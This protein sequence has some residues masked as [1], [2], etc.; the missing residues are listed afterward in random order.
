M[1]HFLPLFFLLLC[2]NGNAQGNQQWGSYFSYTNVVDL[3]QSGSRLFAASQ[4]A[5]FSQNNISGELK[6]ITS[7]DGLKTETISAI[8]YSATYNKTLV[9]SSNGLLVIINANNSI[10]SKNAIVQETTVVAT[11]KKINHIYEYNGIAYLST[12]F[13]IVEF[14][15]ATLEFGDT[16]Y[17][18]PNGAEVAVRQAT[19][20][21][22]YIYAATY[23]GFGIR[24][25]LL[26]NPNLNDFNQWQPQFGG[27][28]W[29][30]ILTYGTGLFAI[31]ND[32][33][34]HR[35]Q[36]DNLV[37]F[38]R[39]P[40]AATD[41]RESSGF[42]IATCA[43]KTI[44]Y[45]SQFLQQLQIN[46]IPGE[47]EDITYTCA[48][49]VGQTFYI[50]TAERGVFSVPMNFS[51]P[52][53][54]IT[55]DGPLR[56]N[57]FSIKKSRNF[58]WAVFGGYNTFYTPDNKRYGVSKLT[59]EGWKNIPYDDLAVFGPFE[60]ISDISINPNNEKEVYLNSGHSGLLK[61]I[62]N[63]P[64]TLY[65]NVTPNNTKLQTVQDYTGTI[66]Y[67]SVRINGGTFDRNNNLWM[68]NAHV[69]KP[70][71]VLSPGGGW[72][73]Y[74]LVDV[75][76]N[77]KTTSYGKML[78]DRNGTK[79]LPTVAEGL[80]GFNEALNNKFIVV[81]AESGL[82]STYVKCVE[83]DN[84]NRLWI[85]TTSGLRTLYADRF[86]TE[87]TLEATNIVFLED[88]VPVEL[89]NEQSIIDIKTDG[90]NNKWIGTAGA[91]AFLV[92]PDGQSTLFHFT[93]DNSP[94][95]S[96]NIND[97]EIDNSTGEV[98]FAT[99]KGLVSYKGTSTEAEDDL[100]NV[101]VY[102]NPVRP[103]F[104]GD[105][106]ISGL[107]NRATVKI[108][109]IE[110]NLVYE[111]TS[112]GGTILWDTRA[113]GKYKVASGVYMIFISSEDASLTKVKKVMVVR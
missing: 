58:L 49:I 108:T 67:T 96:N 53:V 79:W 109:D 85:G 7:V 9:G 50:G 75:L 62:D 66:P 89:M 23:E 65:N 11:K 37:T 77:L 91:G 64:T 35:V 47:L 43:T 95:P 32:G 94:L 41:L 27:T 57:V 15:L 73:E 106:K 103:G 107:V 45:N 3:A 26:A 21:N 59:N 39:L 42:M 18:G 4:N 88:G 69:E 24:R 34:I 30:G 2:L 97:I 70:L 60:S 17:L 100:S 14:N 40:S 101:Y 8:Y 38:G 28:Y 87:N 36:G 51:A 1:K 12:D 92:S 105:V 19:I 111:T 55:P 104:E 29:T 68:T 16:F 22:G 20:Y 56:D 74:S 54:N 99:D 48:T 10:V 31:D 72:T 83:I 81:N 6:T 63:V 110:G 82:E 80:V 90:S 52:F 33:T 61:L 25:A 113:F 5:M 46:A 93:K 13:G 78:I 84:S 76:P 71:K 98:Y 112:E 86:M 102:P 44:V